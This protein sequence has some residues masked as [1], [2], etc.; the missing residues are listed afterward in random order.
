MTRGRGARWVG[1]SK[2]A[3][4][5]A[6]KLACVLSLG[7]AGKPAAQGERVTLYHECGTRT[8]C[9]IISAGRKRSG[10]T[11]EVI[12]IPIEGARREGEAHPGFLTGESHGPENDKG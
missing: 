10:N 11:Q 6:G 2:H 1:A 12:L 3:A 8:E 7:Q 5:H 9:K 4:G